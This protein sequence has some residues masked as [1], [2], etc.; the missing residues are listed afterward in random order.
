MASRPPIAGL[1]D[2]KRI[3]PARRRTLSDAIR[4]Q[5]IS[6]AVAWARVEE[7]ERLNV[8]GA[9]LLAMRRAVQALDRVPRHVLV[10]GPHVPRL[11]M[12]A[13][14]VI[15]GDC[16]VAAI[17]A[18]SILAKVE[19]DRYMK[20]LSLRYPEYGFA[21]HK[22]YATCAH[23]EALRRHGASDVHRRRYAPVQRALAAGAGGTVPA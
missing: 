13:A 21:A 12:P 23:L 18:A 22:G 5:A 20:A 14:P 15:G 2:S 4:A 1:D 10:D 9:S 6:W 7:V 8:L 16:L 19:R 11:D 3:A 17:S